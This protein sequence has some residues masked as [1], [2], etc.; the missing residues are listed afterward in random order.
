MT[1]P[2]TLSVDELRAL[3]RVTGAAMPSFVTADVEHHPDVDLA[4]L[5]GLLARGLVARNDSSLALGPD[6][7]PLLAPA[8]AATRIVELDDGGHERAL[9]RGLS[10]TVLLTSRSHGLVQ[11]A[12]WPLTD[13]ALIEGLDVGDVDRPAD[14]PMVVVAETAHADADELALDGNRAGAEAA[15]RAGGADDHA[16]AAYVTAVLSRRAALKLRV[17]RNLGD[18]PDGPFEA[19]ERRWLVAGAGVAWKIDIGAPRG[20]EEDEADG[21]ALS[22]LAPI[23][24]A[25]LRDELRDLLVDPVTV[26]G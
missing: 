2:I 19:G 21:E 24:A 25:V 12:P 3:G 18:G 15:L 9:V 11:L 1:A 14:G 23:G 22:V 17:A 7:D 16:A 26:G 6:L 10:G 8:R 13:G 5:R 20:D 4:A